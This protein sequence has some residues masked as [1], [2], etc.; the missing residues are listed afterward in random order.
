MLPTAVGIAPAP[1]LPPGVVPLGIADD[2]VVFSLNVQ[3]GDP[4]NAQNEGPAVP[5]LVLPLMK[6]G[7]WHCFLYKYDYVPYTLSRIYSRIDMLNWNASK[8][9]ST[10]LTVIAQVNRICV[11]DTALFHDKTGGTKVCF[12]KKALARYLRLTNDVVVTLMNVIGDIY[13]KQRANSPLD[14]NF[15]VV[16]VANAKNVLKVFPSNSE[17]RFNNTLLLHWKYGKECA[18]T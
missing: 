6:E 17:P 13:Y 2:D 12:T 11:D 5:V 8:K 15:E 10:P 4:E 9:A 1:Q 16:M 14:I 18:N 7:Y 3:N